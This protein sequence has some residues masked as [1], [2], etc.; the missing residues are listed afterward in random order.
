[1]ATLIRCLTLVGT[2]GMT[3]N[4]SQEEAKAQVLKELDQDV[5]SEFVDVATGNVTLLRSKDII[6]VRLMDPASAEIRPALPP[7][8]SDDMADIVSRSID[9]FSLALETAAHVDPQAARDLMLAWE[10]MR[11]TYDLARK[12]IAAGEQG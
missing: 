8:V 6:A 4:G 7:F 3:V 2:Y 11:A 1:M 9:R 10:N 12:N 5:F